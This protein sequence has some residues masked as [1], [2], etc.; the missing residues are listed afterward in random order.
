M[1]TATY[2]TAVFAIF[3]EV[4]NWSH[5][6]GQNW[7][8]ESC[9]LQFSYSCRQNILD[10]LAS[11]TFFNQPQHKPHPF[12]HNGSFFHGIAASWAGFKSSLEVYAMSP[13]RFVK[14]SAETWTSLHAKAGIIETFPAFR[15]PR[16]SGFVLTYNSETVSIVFVVCRSLARIGLELEIVNSDGCRVRGSCRKGNFFGCGGLDLNQ[17][18]FGSEPN[19]L[20]RFAIQLAEK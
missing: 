12:F 16:R 13:E 17:R 19:V 2:A 6:P 1:F 14:C 5:E 9:Q 20:L 10:A 11:P 8:R 3:L 4:N 15:S 7:S 18:L